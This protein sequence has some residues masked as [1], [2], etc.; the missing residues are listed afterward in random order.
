MDKLFEELDEGDKVSEMEPTS[1]SWTAGVFCTLD[2]GR[3]KS[4]Y[5]PALSSLCI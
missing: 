1:V 3:N 2:Y 5:D 4:V